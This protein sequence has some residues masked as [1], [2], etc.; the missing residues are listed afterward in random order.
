MTERSLSVWPRLTAICHVRLRSCSCFGDFG[1]ARQVALT[2]FLKHSWRR[3]RKLH[4]FSCQNSIPQSRHH[5]L[6][7]P[8]SQFLVLRR[9]ARRQI[10]RRLA[11]VP[12]VVLDAVVLVI[13]LSFS[14]RSW[15]CPGTMYPWSAE[16]SIEAAQA[17]T[18]SDRST[19]P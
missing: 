5:Q 11:L 6:P 3:V 19:C 12:A 13:F 4:S 16:S 7:P 2:I 15:S 1:A 14:M 10:G 18:A 9:R 8:G 17:G